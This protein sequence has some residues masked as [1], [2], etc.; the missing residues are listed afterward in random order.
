M[1]HWYIE[2]SVVFAVHLGRRPVLYAHNLGWGISEWDF[3]RVNKRKLPSDRLYTRIH[4]HRNVSNLDKVES[5]GQHD[6]A[7]RVFLPYH[8]PKIVDRVLG[9]PLRDNVGVWLQQ[10]LKSNNKSCNK[11]QINELSVLNG[12]PLNIM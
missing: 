7:T 12:V 11:R 10:A 8:A 2:I 1:Q 6:D 5:L 4:T 3:R 9:G